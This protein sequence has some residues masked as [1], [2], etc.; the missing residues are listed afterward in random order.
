MRSIDQRCIQAP[1]VT[2]AW[3]LPD[4]AVTPEKDYLRRREFLRLAGLGA[5]GLALVPLRSS[6]ASAGFPDSLNPA[7]KLDGVKLTAE[8]LVTGYN[9]F[10]EWGFAKDEPKQLANKG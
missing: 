5:A 7:F 3:H 2:P 6:G 4:T 9:N 1:T 10:Y 8:D